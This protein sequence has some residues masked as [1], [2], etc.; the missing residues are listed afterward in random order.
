[1]QERTTFNDGW[2]ADDFPLTPT[3]GKADQFLWHETLHGFGFRVRA[4]GMRAWYCQGRAKGRTQRHCLGPFEKLKPPQARKLAEHYFA[5]VLLGG[6]PTAKRRKE[7]QEQSDTMLS[8]AKL[9]L[10]AKKPELRKSTLTESTRYLTD[11]GY[12][13]KLHHH[14]I[15]AI[16]RRD[17]AAC[18]AHIGS[19][20]GKVT[21][22][23]ARTCL[24]AMYTW[25]MGEGL[26]ES[27]PVIG[28]NKPWENA[29]RDRVLK[30]EEVVAIWKHCGDDDFGCIMKLLLLCGCRRSEIGALRWSEVN[31]V[32]LTIA[33]SRTKNGKTLVIP[34]STLAK[35]VIESIPH[36]DD[37]AL[38]FGERNETGFCSWAAS[39]AALDAKLGKMEPWKLHD[40]RR[41]FA[42]GLGDLGVQPHV[43]E[44]LLGHRSGFRAS[45][46]GTTYNWSTYGPEMRTAVELWADYVRSLIEGERKIL[47]MHNRKAT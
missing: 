15:G 14:G 16:T 27:N 12:F 31:D 23:R 34:L 39:K 46:A 37:R 40:A 30:P 36:R 32:K 11:N 24:S 10:A 20:R 2:K 3:N 41:T 28:S 17:V 42:S 33:G 47:A 35:E 22:A 8:V 38:V 7:R 21:S 18:V 29:P 1:M 4:S 26:A 45:V 19:Q 6:D 9:Y 5:Q 13:G 43:I 44:C 25:A